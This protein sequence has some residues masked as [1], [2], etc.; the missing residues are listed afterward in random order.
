MR[1]ALYYTTTNNGV[2]CKLCPHN[3]TIQENKVGRCKVRQNIK[4][5]L[6]SLNYNQVSTIQV[7]PIEKKPIMNWMSG[8]EIFSVGSYGC[9]FHCGFC[10]NHSISLALPD[11]IH[12]SPEEIVAQALSLGLPSI[13]YT[14]NEPTVFYE[15][16]LETAKLANEKG[17]KNVIVTNGFINQAPLMEIL[18]YIDAMNIDLKAYD[19]PSY[20][21]LGGKTVEDVLETIKLASKYCHVE[22]TMLIVPTI[23][24]DPKK[25]EEL[26]CKL[27]KEA[28]NIVIHLSRYFPRYQYD[29]PATEIMLMI[30]FKDIAEKYFKY[31]Y[32]GNVR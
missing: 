28:P 3:C 18:P 13:A 1:E 17:L 16:M 4:G 10:Q 12:I 8:S 22:V 7:D 26:L 5:K 30:E 15:M 19:D 27:K 11:T 14:Y 31:V 25:F 32:L 2:E 23:N 29:E 20:H 21:N 9:N 24:D 6:Y